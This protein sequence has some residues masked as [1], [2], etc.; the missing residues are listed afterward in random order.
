M[1][2]RPAPEFA[3]DLGPAEAMIAH[4]QK[5]KEAVIALLQDVQEHYG[6][7][8]RPVLDLIASRLDLPRTQ[9]YS[10]ATFY[11]AFTLRPQ[12]KHK[13]C[14]CTGTACRTVRLVFT[15]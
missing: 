8:P 11:R 13:I 10:L 3:V 6:Y 2:T 5:E 12:G 14:V 1:A 7:L 15:S 9:L 4:Y